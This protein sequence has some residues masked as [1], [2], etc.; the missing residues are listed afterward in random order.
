MLVLVGIQTD[1]FVLFL[2]SSRHHA[3]PGD[4]RMISN[5]SGFWRSQEI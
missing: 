1:T 4:I 2:F 5:K 3:V